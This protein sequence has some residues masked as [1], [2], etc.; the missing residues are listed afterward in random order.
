LSY[1]LI[2]INFT[3]M[4]ILVVGGAG[5]IGSNMVRFLKQHGHHVWVL[6]NLSTGHS[7]AVPADLLIEGDLGD[8]ELVERILGDHSIEGVMHFAAFALVGESVQEPAKYYQNNVV[9]TLNLLES[10]RRTDVKKIV[11]S[12]SCATYGIPRNVPISE[13]ESQQPVNPYGFTK[14]AIERAL[15][16]YAKAYDFGYAALRYFNAA[17]AAEDGTSGEDHDPETH[18]IPIVLQTAL[19]LRS[20]VAIYGNDWSTPDQT[21]IRDYIHINDLAM[22]HLAALERLRP[23]RGIEVNLGTGRGHSVKDV[24]N[25]CEKVTGREIPF[26]Y[27]ARRPGDPPRLVANPKLAQSILNWE[28]GFVDLEQIVQTAWAWHRNFP[29]GY[30]SNSD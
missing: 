4:N 5:Y 13:D 15:A 10:M 26:E 24:I 14:L 17:G 3:G 28:A 27:S 16:D 29:Q 11:F 6:D 20:H 7:Q 30:R 2:F 9:A 12:S 21:C 22:A 1:Y 19:G 8:R 23:G 18:L 25:V